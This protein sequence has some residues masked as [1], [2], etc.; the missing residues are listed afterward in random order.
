[1]RVSN[2]LTKD[3]VD[4]PGFSCLWTWAQLLSWAHQN[5]NYLHSNHWWKR[6]EPT[7]KDLLQLKTYRRNKMSR[8]GGFW[9]ESSPM[10]QVGN[11]QI[12]AQVL[13]QEWEVQDSH[14]TS[15]PRNPAQEDEPPEDL[16][17]VSSVQEDWGK[18]ISLLQHTG[19]LTHS[20]A[21]DKSSN[22]TEAWVR[23]TCCSWR[24]C[25]DAGDKYGSRWGHRCWQ[26]ASIRV[27]STK[28]DTGADRCHCGIISLAY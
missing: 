17:L 11:P 14:Q 8:R 3:R 24:V 27:P 20:G 16:A 23:P 25:R 5:H 21:Q 9:I 28:W 22:L 4:C 7:R 6:L 15:W 2:G 18:Q 12:V 1:M 10:P 26:Q 19:N 13:P